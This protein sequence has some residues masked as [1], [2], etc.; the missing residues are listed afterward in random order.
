MDFTRFIGSSVCRLG[1]SFIH[2]V[3]VYGIAFTMPASGLRDTF[4]VPPNIKSTA[5]TLCSGIR[6]EEVSRLLARGAEIRDIRVRNFSPRSSDTRGVTEIN[7]IQA[8][9]YILQIQILCPGIFITPLPPPS[10]G[11]RIK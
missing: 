11:G 5:R 4:D 9:L 7:S 6:R 1:R 10:R 3:T 8:N 2:R